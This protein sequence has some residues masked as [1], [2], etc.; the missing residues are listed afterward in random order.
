MTTMDLSYNG[1]IV[2]EP[3]LAYHYHYYYYILLLLLVVVLVVLQSHLSSGGEVCNLGYNFIMV[4]TRRVGS[5]V[6]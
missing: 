4:H 3:Y 1:C 6:G 2:R 5:E